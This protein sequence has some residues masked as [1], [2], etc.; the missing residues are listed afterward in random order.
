MVNNLL[1]QRDGNLCQL[2]GE[3][4]DSE[5]ET[6]HIDHILPRCMGG[7]HEAYNLR[8]VHATCNLTRGKRILE[9]DIV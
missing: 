8:L 9:M 4:L 6:L 1:L 7:T 5:N 2:C 3:V